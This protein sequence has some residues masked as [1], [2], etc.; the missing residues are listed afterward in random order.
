[1]WWHTEALYGQMS[2]RPTDSWISWAM[3]TTPWTTASTSRMPSPNHIEAYWCAVKC[4][5]K[6]MAGTSRDMVSPYLEQHM[7]RERY[8]QTPKLALLNLQRHIAEHY[9]V[10]CNPIYTGSFQSHHFFQKKTSCRIGI[11]KSLLHIS[12]VR[13]AMKRTHNADSRHWYTAV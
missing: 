2:G 6:A 3:T 9:P 7:W 11:H 13:P 1:M 8:G 12:Y 5:F 10:W 4:Q